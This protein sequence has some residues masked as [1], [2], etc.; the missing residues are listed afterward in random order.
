MEPGDAARVASAS[1]LFDGPAITGPAEKFLAQPNHHILIAFV[2]AVAAGFVSGV[3]ITHPDKGTEMLLYELSVEENHRRRGIGKAL[4]Q[5]LILL[6][7]ERRCY[8]MWVL[9]DDDNQEAL[10]TYR[11]ISGSTEERPVLFSW[12]FDS[13]ELTMI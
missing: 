5:H 12:T 7:K 11:S 9:A 1:H 13:T 4:I 3:E 6:A 8:G 2:G 10:A